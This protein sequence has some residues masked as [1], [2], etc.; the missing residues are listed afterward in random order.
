MVLRAATYLS[1]ALACDVLVM[2]G[3]IR[4]EVVPGALVGMALLLG[5]AWWQH[6]HEKGHR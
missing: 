4:P 5:M 2:T 6:R 3:A 1:A